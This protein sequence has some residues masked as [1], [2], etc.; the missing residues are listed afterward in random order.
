M[1]LFGRKKNKKKMQCPHCEKWSLV[2]TSADIVNCCYC[3][4]TMVVKFLRKG[5]KPPT[6]SE[7][8]K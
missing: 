3:G 5:D 4:L 6:V 8:I 1:G 7:P 2:D